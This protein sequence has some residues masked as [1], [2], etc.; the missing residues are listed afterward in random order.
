MS[1]MNEESSVAC[2]GRASGDGARAITNL[3]TRKLTLSESRNS[4]E[5]MML[6]AP[7]LAAEWL[8]GTV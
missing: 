4:L 3:Q 7:Q 5:T 8:G 6:E 1:T 2:A